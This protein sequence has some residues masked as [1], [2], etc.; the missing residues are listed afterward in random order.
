MIP[1]TQYRVNES[2]PFKS[3]SM[4]IEFKILFQ[5]LE[6]KLFDC[7][8]ASGFFRISNKNPGL[9]FVIRFSCSTASPY[10]FSLRSWRCTNYSLNC[11][12][13]YISPCIK[14]ASSLKPTVV[15]S[16]KCP[17]VDCTISTVQFWSLI[18]CCRSW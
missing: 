6:S 3:N 11:L 17:V 13:S 10:S 8:L 5:Y 18:S 9:E 2:P 7:N 16:L 15:M 1:S 12:S 14:C 4:L